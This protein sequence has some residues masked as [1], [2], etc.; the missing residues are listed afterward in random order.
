MNLI[1]PHVNFGYSLL[2]ADRVNLRLGGKVGYGLGSLK[3]NSGIASDLS[4]NPT[5]LTLALTSAIGF[6]F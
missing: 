4:F 5:G 1:D 3:V 2:I 6:A